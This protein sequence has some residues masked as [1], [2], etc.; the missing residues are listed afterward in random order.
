M[1]LGCAEGIQGLVTAVSCQNFEEVMR[2]NPQE[3]DGVLQRTAGWKDGYDKRAQ[4]EADHAR[5]YPWIS[6]QAL[7]RR[8]PG[9]I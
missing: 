9:G 7:E 6:G 5:I 4:K 1:A 2:E 3:T 8:M